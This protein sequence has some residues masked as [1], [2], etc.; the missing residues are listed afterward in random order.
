MVLST[1]SG[2]P[3]ACAAAAMGSMSRMS[4]LGLGIDSPKKQVVVSS[5]AAVQEAGSAGSSTKCVV[6]P[7]SGRVW[8]R[9]LMVPPYSDGEATMELP[10]PPSVRKVR[11]SAPMPEATRCAPTPPSSAAMRAATVWLVG[12]SRRV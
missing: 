9:R 10:A 5:A 3:R 8:V 12:L 6:I 4:P 1:T 11:V 7:S 2:T